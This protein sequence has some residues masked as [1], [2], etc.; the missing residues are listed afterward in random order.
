MPRLPLL[1]KALENATIIK[2]G[3]YDYFVNPLQG[4]APP[5]EP[6]LLREIAERIVEIADFDV[7]RIVTIEAMGIHI[8]ALVSSMSNMPFVILRKKK[9]GL[10]GE[11]EV[12][13]K[14]S[15]REIAG[16]ERM[17]TF[18]I[19]SIKKGD[20]VLVIDD[21]MSTGGTVTSVVKGLKKIGAVVKDILIVMNREKGPERVR[22]ET[23]CDVKTLADIEVKE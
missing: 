10:P 19:N 7:D 2:M 22:R 20:R 21:V 13:V 16:G 12:S 9:F 6:E 23:G 18:Y 14:K 17:E 15:Y 4:V 1:E 3:R 5:L 8:S 11:V